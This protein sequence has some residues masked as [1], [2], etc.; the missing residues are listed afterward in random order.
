MYL[1]EFTAAVS[2]CSLWRLQARFELVN[3]GAA[4]AVGRFGVIIP[5]FTLS[6]QA[7]FVVPSRMTGEITGLEALK[8]ASRQR[9]APLGIDRSIVVPRMASEIKF[10][11]FTVSLCSAIVHFGQ[12]M[13][14]SLLA[15][16]LLLLAPQTLQQEPP[17]AE[18]QPCPVCPSPSPVTCPTCPDPVNICPSP[19]ACPT[20][21]APR[22]CPSTFCPTCP[23][24]TCPPVERV[25][26][27]QAP[28]PTA[29]PPAET[30]R[31][32]ECDRG[33][34]AVGAT[35][36]VG[37][38]GV[39]IGIG[40]TQPEHCPYPPN[41]VTSY[42][43]VSV[44]AV[45][46]ITE[47]GP[48]LPPVTITEPGVPSTITIT[49]PGPTLPPVTVTEPGDNSTVTI[50]EPGPTLPPV[51]ITEP[52][53]NSTLTLTEPG[54]TL[55]PVTITEPGDNS[56]ITITEPGPTL[57]PVTITEPGTNSTV[58]LTE[59]GPTLPPV[60]VTTTGN[61]SITVIETSI[62]TET[63]VEPTTE[64]ETLTITDPPATI[65]EPAVPPATETITVTDEETISVTVTD[66]EVTVT[67]TEPA[68]TITIDDP[69]ATVT[70]TEPGETI[71]VADPEAT[72]TV[73]EPA[74]TITIEDP[75]ATVTVTEA[76]ET[77]T[78]EDPAAT[79]T[80]TEAAETVTIEDPE[81]TIT[82]TDP[83][84]T[85]TAPG[86]PPEPPVT[87]PTSPD[88]PP[89]V[90]AGTSPAAPPAV[91]PTAPDA[92]PAVPPT[93]PAAPPT[94]PP[95]APTAAPP[96]APPSVVVS[97]VTATRSLA[98]PTPPIPAIQ[99]ADGVAVLDYQRLR[100]GSRRLD[101]DLQR[102]REEAVDQLFSNYCRGF[103]ARGKT[104]SD[105]LTFDGSEDIKDNN[106]RNAGC[107]IQ[108]CRD[109]GPGLSCNQ[110]PFAITSEGGIGAVTSCVDN[111]AQ[112]IQGAYL[113][114]LRKQ[115]GLRRGNKF[116]F[117]LSGFDCS[118]A[119][120]E[121]NATRR[122]LPA[123]DFSK[124]PLLPRHIFKRDLTLG[125]VEVQE[126]AF[127]PFNEYEP[128]NVVIN[129][130]G[131]LEAGR[132]QVTAQVD[133]GAVNGA[134]VVDNEGQTYNSS[135][136]QTFAEQDT[137]LSFD[138]LHDALGMSF[139]LDTKLTELQVTSTLTSA[140]P[141][142]KKVSLAAV[143][144]SSAAAAVF[145]AFL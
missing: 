32:F 145:L 117:S 55:P 86:E 23:T 82:V 85:V 92:P 11:S 110:Y 79:I 98:A 101:G 5:T 33:G 93:A 114:G 73:T 19:S 104:D 68:E 43:T 64:I 48:T 65:T 96:V 105:E 112:S 25:F 21:P 31:I 49:E 61:V 116:T 141:S 100:R 127:P 63:I 95:A 140:A 102:R 89:A 118:G 26:C 76:A 111:L 139:F 8:L 54:P 34:V 38:V 70:V 128:D 28:S 37:D 71:T 22:E 119:S 126:Q 72:I 6:A 109:E 62:T 134:R 74:E 81:A 50:T 77:I 108:R 59:P 35:V 80:V 4:C 27:P 136:I 94:A 42:V 129:P 17:V 20:C 107:T 75:E 51:T 9:E 91:P 143:L 120:S 84:V 39:G 67:I 103:I 90:V 40:H 87:P 137:T 15:T 78:V 124:A 41:P 13:Q 7:P 60:T 18:P 132:Y 106:R 99:V 115:L 14:W 138:L 53:T 131:D 52:G 56:T 142:M 135:D 121:S 12:E 36:G 122:A 69:E 10:Y 24:P 57:P 30:V 88:A 3:P 2:F 16:V 113:S 58:T 44:T 144:G 123:V 130:M 47:P 45:V 133:T 83:A 29:C 66:P 97:T 1:Q 46:T 125:A